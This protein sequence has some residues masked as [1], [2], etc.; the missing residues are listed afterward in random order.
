MTGG[1][2]YSGNVVQSERSDGNI[3]ESVEIPFSDKNFLQRAANKKPQS[4]LEYLRSTV[5]GFAAGTYSWPFD[6]TLCLNWI[7]G[8]AGFY[9]GQIKILC[10]KQTKI[11]LNV[12][13]AAQTATYYMIF[14][15]LLWKLLNN[16]DARQLVK[17]ELDQLDIVGQL[18]NRLP[19]VLHYGS[20]MVGRFMSGMAFTEWMESGGTLR[21]RASKG[22]SVAISTFNLLAATWGAA[23]HASLK[24]GDAIDVVQIFIS[25]ITGDPDHKLSS[26]EYTELFKTA[27]EL[28]EAAL[29]DPKNAEDFKN[30]QQFI[31]N[32]LHF[33]AS[34]GK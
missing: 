32:W 19:D 8:T 13:S 29:E 5:S 26:S 6:Y 22:A 28:A 12:A 23:L 34:G 20:R 31:K 2:T 10:D 16:E 4:T 9:G 33:G 3:A 14:R 24:H 15:G 30:Y 7:A 27:K 11:I 21:G 1:I 25:I 18:A 17:K